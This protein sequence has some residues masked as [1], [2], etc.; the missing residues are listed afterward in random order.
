[1]TMS[2]WDQR[3][4]RFLVRP[5]VKTA[6]TPNHV[7]GLS[8]LAGIAATLAFAH[9][10]SAAANLGAAC[11]ML[12]MLI[13][14]ADGELARMAGKTSRLGHHLDYIVG[15][16]N[17]T[18][19]FIGLGVGVGR[20]MGDW[21]LA[22]GLAAGFSNPVVVTV[23]MLMERRFGAVSVRHPSAYGF[24]IEDFAYLI[25]PIT[26]LFGPVYFLVP[27]GLG[28]LGYLGWTVYSYVRERRRG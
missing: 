10:G 1:M 20:T 16:L 9:G 12:A 27:Y 14:H 2:P 24:E 22:I 3:L 17:Y 25:G 6:L 26:W 11:F 4:A 18:L 7:T 21:A 28:T 5:F 8:L 15:S 13:D 23:R 19:L